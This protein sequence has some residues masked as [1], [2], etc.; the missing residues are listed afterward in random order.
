MVSSLQFER[1]AHKFY[2]YQLS[3]IFLAAL[4]RV[5]WHS[6]PIPP[7]VVKTIGVKVLFSFCMT[8]KL[9]A[10]FFTLSLSKL[11]IDNQSDSS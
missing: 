10:A 1:D 7:N 6:S 3:A 2:F 8:R 4:W 9:Q 11:G 5:L